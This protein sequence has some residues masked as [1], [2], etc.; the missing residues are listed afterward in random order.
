VGPRARVIFNHGLAPDRRRAAPL[1]TGASRAWPAGA[2]PG[3]RCEVVSL[4][5]MAATR[6]D[7]TPARSCSPPFDLNVVAWTSIVH[8][9]D[10]GT[11]RPAGHGEHHRRL[12]LYTGE[13]H[14]PALVSPKG[15]AAIPG[16]RRN[17]PQHAVLPSQRAARVA[18]WMTGGAA[19]S[20]ADLLASSRPAAG[21]SSQL[22]PGGSRG[23]GERAVAV[24]Q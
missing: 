17:Q 1:A 9:C 5:T 7:L 18:P 19:S 12:G 22:A 14:R 21:S 24:Q 4:P 6:P 3:Q 10:P 2:A 8:V 16:W 11:T 23:L 20:L 13:E 15:G